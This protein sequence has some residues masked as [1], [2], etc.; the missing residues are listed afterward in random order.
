[1]PESVS[2]VYQL[3]GLASDTDQPMPVAM[4]QQLEQTWQ[5]IHL[6]LGTEFNFEFWRKCSPR[7]STYPACRAVIAA[8]VQGQEMEMIFE[9]QRAYYLCAKNP[10][11]LDTLESLA[12]SLGLDIA[13]FIKD[14]S[15]EKTEQVLASQVALAKHWNVPGYPSL[16]LDTAGRLTHIPVDYKSSESTIARISLELAS[17]N[18]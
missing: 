7:R 1:L 15:S 4:R 17:V 13:E 10:S 6:Q 9:I 18:A 8:Q 11:D 12:E 16:V 3:G 2:V 5:R 14:M